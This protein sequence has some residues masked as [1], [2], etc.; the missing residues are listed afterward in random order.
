MKNFK[1]LIKSQLLA[2]SERNGTMSKKTI[3]EQVVVGMGNIE[4]CLDHFTKHSA[5][6]A[7][8]KS[9]AIRANKRVLVNNEIQEEA[10]L[11]RQSSD[12]TASP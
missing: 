6:N 8:L 4:H 2:S 10:L 3:I 1:E 12:S 5:A 7:G 9:T 11:G